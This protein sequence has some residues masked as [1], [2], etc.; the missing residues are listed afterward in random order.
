MIGKTPRQYFHEFWAIKDV[1]FEIKKGETMGIIGRNGSGK[2]TLLQLISG[3]LTPTNGS[4]A[5]HGRIAAL[6]ELGSGFNPEFTGRENVYMNAAVLG[7]SKAD[8]DTRFDEI[9]SF[10]DIGDFI[11][12]PV[13]MY[14]SGMYVRLA[15]A[16]QANVD[17]EILIVDEA[18]A[19]GDAYFVHKCM[20][21]FHKL[22]ETGTTILFVSHDATAV[23]TL[24]N[25]AVW[26]DQGEVVANGAS[27][28]VVDQYLSSIKKQPVVIDFSSSDTE[29]KKITA[30]NVI[31]SNGE[32]EIPN[33]DRRLGDQSC[34][35]VGIGLYNHEMENA[36]II[37]N[38]SEIWLRTTFKNIGLNQ[39]QLLVMGYSLRNSRGVDIAS[40]NSEIEE[41]IITAPAM[42]DNATV[43]VGI[44]LPLLHPGSYSLSVSLGY[45]DNGGVMRDADSITNAVVFD[46]TSKKM[47]HVLMSLKTNF[48]IEDRVA[49]S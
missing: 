35:F 15:F 29:R 23:K 49:K 4:V 22:R 36:V 9:A 19:V 1:S 44:E 48:V 34:V 30:A 2:S 13:K 40:T 47:I 46:V 39:S 3:T 37:E 18:L 28:M 11:E 6:L 12:Q 17:P 45:R 25:S 42:G 14:S 7:L 43:R 20:S 10:A 32:H 38:D 41:K 24:C 8:I 33:I 21:R 26:I 5:T 31:D 27:G 16:I